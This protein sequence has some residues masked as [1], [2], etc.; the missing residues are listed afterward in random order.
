ML[1]MRSHRWQSFAFL[2]GSLFILF[3]NLWGRTLENH[4]Y[5]RYAEV[6]KEMIQTGDWIV[7]RLNGEIFIHKP[8]LL[9]W[10]IAIP[11]Y[12]YGTVTPFLA[13]LPSAFF[14][15]IGG[16][17][18]YLWGRQILGDSRSGF[19]SSGVLLSSYLYFSQGRMARTDMV[20]SVF[21]LLS[22]YF[23]YLGYQRGS[24]YLT[25]YSFTFIGLAGLTKGPVGLALPLSVI[26]LFLLTQ[27]QLKLL[28][29][30][31]F[32]FGYFLMVLMLG[33]WLLPFLYHVGW[34]KAVE[35]WQATRI[36]TRHAPFYLYG[37][38]IWTDFAPWAVF[39]PFMM[40]KYWKKARNQDEIFLILWFLG[41][42]CLLTFFPY[43]ASKYLLPSFPA[44]ALLMGRFWRNR[45]TL[46]FWVFFLGAIVT[47]HGYEMKL[48]QGNEKRSPG[49]FIEKELRPFRKDNLFAYQMDI[50][51]LGKINFYGD[52]I[53]PQVNGIEGLERQIVGKK[54]ALVITPQK[55][56]EE[57]IKE[58]F[59]IIPIKIIEHKNMRFVLAKI[60]PSKSHGF[61]L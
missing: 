23:F 12:L 7:P 40:V 27:R 14:A 19:I 38:R 15:W 53:I 57:L 47:W 18:V 39:L 5:L 52:P 51:L 2:G 48:I 56:I 31:G 32:L 29:Q 9:F 20:F 58:G 46:L 55:G 36:L 16:I 43:R 24:V 1:L 61:K 11:S 22:L 8:P 35:A 13:R 59:R 37:L 34:D 28:F 41:L 4:D 45:S 26:I 60:Q 49:I 30:R 3:F 33:L 10:L 42:F 54:E 50:D 44:L 6:A 25:V 21:V 17:V